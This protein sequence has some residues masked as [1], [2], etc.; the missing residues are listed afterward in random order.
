MTVGDLF[1]SMEKREDWS[2]TIYVDGVNNNIIGYCN[3]YY[4]EDGTKNKGVGLFK[5]PYSV[6]DLFKHNVIS[7]C[8]HMN[9]ISVKIERGNLI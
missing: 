9:G 3:S 6:K 1:N 7:F 2:F 5:Y 4:D 8:S